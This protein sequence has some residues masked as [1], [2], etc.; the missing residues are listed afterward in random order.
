M[1]RQALLPVQ[2]RKAGSG[3]GPRAAS[4][5]SLPGQGSQVRKWLLTPGAHTF[6]YP[7]RPWGARYTLS[8]LILGAQGQYPFS[9]LPGG[10]SVTQSWNEGKWLQLLLRTASRA[11]LTRL[12]SWVHSSVPCYR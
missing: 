9:P 4:W 10:N 1:R 6:T 2:V 8:V 3:I 7:R 12:P 11:A 5:A